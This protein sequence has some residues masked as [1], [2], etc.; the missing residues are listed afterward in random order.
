MRRTIVLPALVCAVVLAACADRSVTGPGSTAAPAVV[1]AEA[2]PVPFKL[3]C[4][5]FNI[6]SEVPDPQAPAVVHVTLDGVC[7]GSHLGRA[8]VHI[9][10]IGNFMA[11]TLV[12]DET[13]TAANGDVL[14]IHHSGSLTPTGATSVSFGGPAAIIGGTGRFVG[15]SG[16]G[17]F[18]GTA[19]AAA[20]TGSYVVEA[21]IR[22]AASAGSPGKP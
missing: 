15:A 1:A 19:D 18:G 20:A 13:L 14:L 22:Y 2:T 16:E 9:D 21:M 10:Q 12:G 4:A 7:Q 6:V 8:T 5:T 17:T 3:Q 11:G